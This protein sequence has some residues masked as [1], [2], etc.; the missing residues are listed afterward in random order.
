MKLSYHWTD[1]ANAGMTRKS[2]LPPSPNDHHQTNSEKW[3]SEVPISNK[4]KNRLMIKS[5]HRRSL[6][7]VRSASN[8]FPI[9][10][11]NAAA[12]IFSRHNRTTLA[13]F[14]ICSLLFMLGTAAVAHAQSL[15]TSFN[16]GANNEVRAL[17]VQA[18]GKILVGGDFTALGG[19]GT[20]T[21]TRNFLGR[22]NADGSLDTG[23][24]PGANGAVYALAVQADGKILVGGI[25]TGLGGSPSTGFNPRNRI[26]RL[27]PDGS[28]D[29]SFN[30]G[31]DGSVFAL[32]VQADGKILV[33]GDFATLGGAPR[34]SIGR[35]GANGAPDS[36]NPG[37][38]DKI[39]AVAVQADGKV[40]VG[41][42]FIY[43]GGGGPY[44]GSGRNRIGRLN[45]D[46]SLDTSVGGN[47]GVINR[48]SALSVQSDGKILVGGDFTALGFGGGLVG[49]ATRNYIGRLNANGSLDTSFNPGA[50]SSSG[51]G[52][53]QALVV[54][55]DGKILVGGFFYGLGGGT[56]T[57]TRNHLGRINAD[58]TVDTSFNPGANT[59]VQALAVQADGKIL[60]GGA[61]TSLGGGGTGTTTRNYIGR[62]NP[63]PDTTPPTTSAFSVSPTSL[64]VGNS[65][66]ISFTV[67]DTGGSGLSGLYL[68]RAPDAGGSPGTWAQVGPYFNLSGNG[69]S[70]NTFTDTPASGKW[71]YGFVVLDGAGNQNN[72]QNQY[73]GYS[74]DF[75]PVEVTVSAPDTTPPTVS[76]GNPTSGQT[77]TASPVA[78]NG[79]ANDPGS[80]S[81]GVSLVQVQVNG[82]GGTWQSASGTTSWTASAALVSGANTIYV[83]SKDGAGNYSTTIASVNVTYNPPDTTPPTV[84]ITA[85][86]A[87]KHMTNALATIVG[88]ARDNLKV[89]SVWYQVNSNAWN[90]VTSTT[91]SYTNWTQTVTLITGSNTFKT[92]ARDFAGNSSTTQSLSVLSSNTF[93]LQLAFTNALP[94]KTN[95]LVFSLL[96]SKGLNGHIQVSSNLTSWVTLTNF[97]GTNT[98]LNFRDP[99][100]TNSS[101]RFYRAVVP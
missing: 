82:T 21:T 7:G 8:R 77:F 6:P 30:P 32:V 101:R 48:I 38:N 14:W 41:G 50:S 46:G 9:T 5:I 93:K 100:A 90:L 57:T 49:S 16:P 45:A 25:F 33:G 39:W 19:G 34:Y 65:V 63:P 26:G 99:A 4:T 78:V 10:T 42:D 73:T 75:P 89:A 83:R 27:N 55:P 24:N 29:T 56:G 64:T 91:N 1:P 36:F 58:G 20:G 2:S 92:Y 3:F 66:N 85:P 86:T 40:W 51:Y 59:T 43:L 15:D 71:W 13:S 97:V 12:F 62:L 79:T 22:L 69:P 68:F 52:G 96:L 67:S 53:V 72:E 31:A 17:A 47:D 74:P 35:L 84:S 80:P 60:V 54:Q 76:I 70:S 98:T 88:T 37:A 11:M 81:T 44:S 23:F 94:M 87:G 18:D 28:L 95:G 61:F